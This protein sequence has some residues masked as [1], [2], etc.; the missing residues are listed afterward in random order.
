MIVP[1]KKISLVVL[2]HE[3]KEALEYLRETG[4]MH[5]EKRIASSQD[6]DSLSTQISKLDQALSIIQ[7][8][9]IPKKTVQN[10]Y[11]SEVVS[12][13]IAETVID[14]YG[15][16]QKAFETK[17]VLENEIERIKPW[18]AIQPSDFEYLSSK[19]THLI[20]CEVS[21]VDFAHLEIKD[22]EILVVQK[23]KKIVRFLV[24]SKAEYNNPS[25]PPEV[26]EFVLPSKS[27]Q[28]LQTELEACNE[29]IRSSLTLI[30]NNASN[31]DALGALKAELKEDLE[32]ETIYAGMP[33]IAPSDTN[34]HAT[35]NLTW[36]K[37]FVPQDSVEL[38][39]KAAKEHNW[40]YICEE[41]HEE[42]LVPTKIKNNRFVNIISPLLD[43]L[44][45]VPGYRE[46]DIS[47]W[48][49]LFF[50]IFFAMIFGD[51]GYGTLLVGITAGIM[52]STKIKGKQIPVALY[53]FLYLGLMTVAWGIITCTWFG[54]PVETLPSFFKAI[55][56]PAFSNVNPEAATNIKIFCFV[57]GLVQISLAHVI[58]FIKNIRSLKCIGE[59][60]SL[61]L[62][63]GMFYVVLS[64]VVDGIKYPL[65]NG[66]GTL[67]IYF[68]IGGFLLNFI[69]IN[70]D[71][72]FV[73]G[74]ID[75]L[76]DSISMILGVVN[77]FGDIMSY[78]RLWA[79]GLAGAAISS[80]INQMAGPF[81]GGFIIFAGALL[82]LFGHG[83]NMIMN[84]L[85]VIV[86]GVRLNTLE[87][88][89]HLGLTWSGFKY[90]PFK[91]TVKK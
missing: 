72:K 68:V 83:L 31:I 61:M 9:G 58:G 70:Y 63:F 73:A 17:T 19:G 55:A 51:G 67:M 53:M 30:Q 81:L 43:F 46:A 74:V 47:L 60:G 49:L 57:L 80:T 39:T 88:S 82:L 37:G 10:A 18:G 84:V 15:K 12:L 16:R 22:A 65:N 29:Q 38:V 56:V 42:D 4:V 27:T 7:D 52:V 69:F 35:Q 1:M 85:S 23:D 5:V 6:I 28:E 45:T 41:P 3:Q 34:E 89:N 90:E 33:T 40:A 44:G 11:K 79:V 14:L 62:A 86:H 78:I 48:F 75:S 50:G 13:E 77:M 66:F 20:P 76:K 64:L 87:F 25:L 54:I 32:F 21:S 36:L 8:A 91:K 24:V 71:G 2:A 26:K 59:L